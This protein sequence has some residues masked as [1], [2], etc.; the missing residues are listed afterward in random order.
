MDAQE[1]R[2]R[3][4]LGSKQPFADEQLEVTQ[5]AGDSGSNPAQ[6]INDSVGS[7]RSADD[8]AP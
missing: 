4:A 6:V 7:V 8:T 3:D 2:T 1:L 5:V